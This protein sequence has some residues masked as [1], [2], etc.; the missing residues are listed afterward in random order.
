[1]DVTAHIIMTYNSIAYKKLLIISI[2]TGDECG[3]LEG[4]ESIV[5]AN[6][7]HGLR[8]RRRGGWN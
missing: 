3:Q 2:Y 4:S 6:R 1:M 7:G 5:R 8:G